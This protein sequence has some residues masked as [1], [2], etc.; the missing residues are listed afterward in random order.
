[1]GPHSGDQA[2]ID[3][4]ILT[5][6]ELIPIRRVNS[7]KVVM[8]S[9]LDAVGLQAEVNV[10][11]PPVIDVVLIEHIIQAFVQALQVQQNHGPPC[12][13]ANLDLINVPTNL[14]ESKLYS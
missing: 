13:H 10:T 2:P 3:T 7:L 5:P 11:T 14:K 9:A 8:H 12:F 6:K 4:C 1:M